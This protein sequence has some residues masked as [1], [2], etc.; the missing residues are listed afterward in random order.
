MRERRTKYGSHP[1]FWCGRW[2]PSLWQ[3][4]CAQMFALC[5]KAGRLSWLCEEVKFTL[6]P[7]ITLRVDFLGGDNQGRVAAWD[8][9]GIETR[10]FRTKARVW[11]AVM[12]FPLHILKR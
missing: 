3:R 1:T 11:K 8:A 4:E 12:P 6:M 5:I 10:D 9:K 7:G 2:Y